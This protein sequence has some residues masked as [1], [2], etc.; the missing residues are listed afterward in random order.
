M[1][2]PQI[3]N[4]GSMGVISC[5]GQGGLHSLSARVITIAWCRASKR[6]D[7]LQR[8]NRLVAIELRLTCAHIYLQSDNT[9]HH[10]TRRWYAGWRHYAVDH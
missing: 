3:M 9:R 5:L 4:L 10:V 7:Y 1:L 6:R 2:I 8:N